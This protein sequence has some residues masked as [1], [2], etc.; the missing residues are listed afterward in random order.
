M[1]IQI[2]SDHNLMGGEPLATSVRAT[3]EDALSRFRTQITR[4]EVHLGD[5]NA[6]KSGNNDKRCMIEARLEGLQP[7]AV[8]EHAPTVAQA[9][10]GAAERLVHRL[11]HTLGRL[12]DRHRHTAP[13]APMNEPGE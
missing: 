7:V 6:G 11:E 1:Q 12:H 3:V 9:I 5:E 10:D 13:P 2:N 8:T 4:V